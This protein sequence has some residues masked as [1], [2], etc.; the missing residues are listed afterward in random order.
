MG[1]SVLIDARSETDCLGAIAPVA[2]QN[3]TLFSLNKME[4]LQTIFKTFGISARPSMAG[5][6]AT[7]LIRQM[8]GIQGC[9]VFKIP[10][11]RQLIEQYGPLQ[12]FT[13]SNAIQT[14]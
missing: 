8:G 12:S 6:L 11:V 13:K 2:A 1:K 5:R 7:G 9:R 4:R 10:G 3:L 14:I